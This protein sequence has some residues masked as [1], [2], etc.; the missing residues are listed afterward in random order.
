MEEWVYEFNDNLIQVRNGK[1]VELLVNGA[2]QDNITGVHLKA[3]LKGVL[4]SGQVIKATLSGL[5]EVDCTL[6]VDDGHP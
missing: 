2:V 1:V 3:E 5:I 6:S 4:P